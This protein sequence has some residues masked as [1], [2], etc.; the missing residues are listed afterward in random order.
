MDRSSCRVG[1]LSLEEMDLEKVVVLQPCSWKLL[2]LYLVDKKKSNGKN[3]GNELSYR[4]SNKVMF[5]WDMVSS[6]TYFRGGGG[7]GARRRAGVMALSST[8]AGPY[9]C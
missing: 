5:I 9:E 1:M 8:I 7:S 4:E 3:L 2:W 6:S